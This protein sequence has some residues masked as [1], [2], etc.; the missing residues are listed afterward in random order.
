MRFQ[1]VWGLVSPVGVYGP[2]NS[3][4]FCPIKSETR[5]SFGLYLML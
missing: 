3:P 4:H 5:L 2:Y 1:L